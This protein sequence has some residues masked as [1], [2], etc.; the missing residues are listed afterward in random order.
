LINGFSRYANS[1]MLYNKEIQMTGK[2]KRNRK[3]KVRKSKK[4][5]QTLTSHVGLLVIILLSACSICFGAD[6]HRI[7]SC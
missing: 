4:K 2:A 6:W 7:L 5:F 3:L 1:C